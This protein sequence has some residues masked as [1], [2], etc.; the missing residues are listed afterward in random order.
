MAMVTVRQLVMAKF[1][2]YLRCCV[3]SP[4]PSLQCNRV[5]SRTVTCCR[6]PR[7]GFGRCCWRKVVGQWSAGACL[8]EW[9]T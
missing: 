4:L 6:G 5:P 2:L 9:Q 7:R 8:C 1:I 3:L